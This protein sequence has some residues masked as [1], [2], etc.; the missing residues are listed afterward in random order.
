MEQQQIANTIIQ[1]LGGRGKLTAM[2][3]MW[4]LTQE[5]N[6]TSFRFKRSK[7]ANYVK[8]ILNGDTYTVEFMLINAAK[9]I[10]QTTKTYPL[11]YD[12]MLKSI[13][14]N[15]TGLRLSL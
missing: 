3:G 4:N 10:C 2:I 6:G 11:I 8:I 13:F 14:Q 5:V 15:Y 12:H 7:V 1:Q 9:G